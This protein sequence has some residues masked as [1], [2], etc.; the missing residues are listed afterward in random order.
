M[1][2]SLSRIIYG[3]L[4]AKEANGEALTVMALSEGLSIQDG[5]LWRGLTSLQP[6][7]GKTA[8][9]TR[10]L[11]LF[12]GPGDRFVFACAY[13]QDGNPQWPLYEYVLLG[14]DVL[15]ALAGNLQPLIALFRDPV[16]HNHNLPSQIPPAEIADP[17]PW[18]PQER[19]ACVDALLD[20]DPAQMPRALALLGAALHERG[21]LLYDFPGDSEAR[22]RL[23]QGLMALLPAR[24]RPD[25]TFST[26]RHERTSTHARLVF[27][28]RNVTS[29]RWIADWS[30]QT[31]PPSEA[32]TSPYV[33]RLASLWNGDIDSL[34]RQIDYMEAIADNVSADKNMQTTLAAIAE[35]HTLDSRVSAGESVPIEAIKT[36]LK[37][38]PP[39][40]ELKEVYATRLLQ[41]ALDARD[42]DAAITVASLMDADPALDERLYGLLNEALRTQPD[43][44]YAFIRARLSA[45]LD[46]RW[47]ARLKMAALASLQIAIT[48][49]DSETVVNWLRLVAREPASYGLTDL[50]HNGILAA[51]ERARTDPNLAHGLVVLAVRR[52]PA[53]AEILTS[54]SELMAVLPNSLGR[55]LRDHEGD[56]AALLQAHGIETLLAALARAARVKH[57]GLFTPMTIEQTWAVYMGGQ[58]VSAGVRQTAEQIINSWVGEGAVWLST[59]ALDTLLAVTLRDRRDDLFHQL[60]HPLAAREDFVTLLA[61]ALNHSGRSVSDVLALIAQIVAAGDLSQQDAVNLYIA[62]LDQWDWAQE[63]LPMMAQLARAVQQTPSLT[64]PDDVLWQLLTVAADAKDDMIARVVVR[65]ITSDLDAVEDDA[66][67]IEDLQQLVGQIQWSSHAR[68]QLLTWW[69]GFARAQSLSRLQRLDKALEGARLLDEL[70]GVVQSLIA[71]RRM[72]GKR[73]LG[74]FAEDVR[75]A[76]TV[77]QLLAESY[78]PSTKRTLG[79]D[80]ATIR[81][82]FDARMEEL[83]PHDLKILANDLKELA[84]LVGD[85]GDNRSKASLMRRGDDI[86]RQ[87]MTGEQ[88]PHSA[89]DA[90]KWMSGYLAGMH[91]KPEQGEE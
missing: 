86:D 75:V 77:L 15:A 68:N 23:T 63:R 85:M 39:Q 38:A 43:A 26:N 27:A 14:R 81:M 10:A 71:F 9:E 19:R 62:L 53:A 29:G 69:R 1:S 32:Q 8:A 87:L 4:R 60:L 51:Q 49:G 46:E 40:G 25:L 22:G 65:R 2:V 57:P 80:P 36:T 45:S 67:L 34:L 35:R 5:I 42:T 11:G 70:R 3:H 83:S 41:H 90:L 24:A 33:Q 18:T 54:D 58:P 89:V 13:S 6:M 91:E 59:P 79:F 73:A 78:D 52:D 7:P 30:A 55:A 16:E 76:F 72:L 47:L 74:Q 66:R 20:N 50:V 84:E 31:F 61:N 44:V 48:D 88:P 21:L 56:P 17:T 82:E 12:A 37:E 64:V 28:E